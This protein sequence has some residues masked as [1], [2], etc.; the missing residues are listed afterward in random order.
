METGKTLGKEEVIDCMGNVSFLDPI[1][2][3]ADI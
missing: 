3:N 1:S 2:Y